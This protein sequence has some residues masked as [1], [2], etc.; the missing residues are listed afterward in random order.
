MRKLRISLYLFILVSVI[1]TTYYHFGEG[2]S[3]SDAIFMIAITLSTV[4]Y[5]EV[6]PLSTTGRIVTVFIIIFGITITGYT[7]GTFIRMLIE[8]ELGK[9]FGRKKV[10]KKIT[11]LKNHYIICGYGRIGKILTRE[12]KRHNEKFVVLEYDSAQ[13]ANLESMGVPYMMLDARDENALLKA[14]IMRAKG[15]VTA[16]MS[17]ADNVF[18]TLTA[19]MLRPDIYI[20]ARSS[21]PKNEK[22]LESAGASKVVSP[23]LIGGQRMAQLLVSPTVV[24]FIDIATMDDRLGLRME[25]AKISPKSSYVGKSLIESNL[26]KDFGVIIVLI[27]KSSGEM[28][29]NPNP[30]EILE[31]NDVLVMLGKI[32]DLEK[33]NAII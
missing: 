23:Y 3:I 5:G 21:D 28:K 32:S 6:Q 13:I 11:S 9:R 30:N 22:K 24:D 17:D 25:E 19:R 26:R 8:G 16:V 18:I 14:G 2:M 31:E 10:E 29:F 33:I 27:K 4:G 12:L 7:A 20:L 15:L 1:G